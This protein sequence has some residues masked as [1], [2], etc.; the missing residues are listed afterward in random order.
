MMHGLRGAANTNAPC[1]IDKQYSRHLP[2]RFIDATKVDDERYPVYGRRDNG[3]T[4]EKSGVHLD[5]RY[6]VPYNAELLCKY[7]K[8]I[9]VE[10]CNQSRS[11]K[12]LFKYINKGY[13]RAIS[14]AYQDK[15]IEDEIK[16]TDK[17][18]MYYD[19]RFIFGM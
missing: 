14:V 3:S 7:H 4:F 13:D 12:Y 10:W 1:M 19:C 17:I 5:N 16:K 15:Q 8:Y 9:N 2:K 18:K 6:V 11:I